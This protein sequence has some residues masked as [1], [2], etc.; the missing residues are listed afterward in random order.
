MSPCQGE[1]RGFE[2]HRPLFIF[3]MASW[4]SGKARVCKTLITGS[5]PVDA[6]GEQVRVPALFFKAGVVANVTAGKEHRGEGFKTPAAQAATIT[7]RRIMPAKSR[8]RLW[9]AGEACSIAVSAVPRWFQLYLRPLRYCEKKMQ[10]EIDTTFDF[11]TDT[12]PGKDP[13]TYSPTLRKYHKLLWSKHLPGGAQFELVD[14]TPQVYLHHRSEMGEFWLSS[15]AVVPSFTRE[16]KIAHIIEQIS[17]GE[18]DQ[19]NTIGY[20]IGGMMV[21]PGQRVGGKMTIN[22][23][24]GFHPLIKDR[25]D[26]TMECIRRHYLKELSPLSDTLERYADF[27]SLFEHFR[28]YIESFLLQDIITDDFSEVKFFLPFGDFKTSPLPSDAESYLSYKKLAVD[29]IEA[30]NR[31]ILAFWEASS[32]A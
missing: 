10:S 20:T 30:R 11:R 1:G 5:N 16:Y 21:F 8:R 31:R 25:F 23:A 14:T 18:L 22:V 15:D 6:S 3:K 32:S 17:S 4:P 24:R 12:P 26:L 7:V 2:S 28:G 19:F 13:D 9:R 29:F 27:F